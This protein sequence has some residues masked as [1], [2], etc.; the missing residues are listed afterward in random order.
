M[1][2][3]VWD[4]PKKVKRGGPCDGGPENGYVPQM[5]DDDMNNWKGKH[6]N[7]G[8]S[9]ARIELRKTFRECNEYAQ[10]L[11]IISDKL[12]PRHVSGEMSDSGNIRIST[13]GTIEVTFSGW[14]E[15]IDVINEAK[16]I[17]NA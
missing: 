5:S 4:T 3:I 14:K 1:S 8:K 15:I 13:N 10:V 12:A 17:L 7:K 2:L 9:D 16:E 6:I 11:I